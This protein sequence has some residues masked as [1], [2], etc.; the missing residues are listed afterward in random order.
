MLAGFARRHEIRVSAD[1][2]ERRWPMYNDELIRRTPYR[3]IASLPLQLTP[4]LA[5]AVDLYFYDPSGAFTVDLAAAVPIAELMAAALMVASTPTKPSTRV[6]GV[7]LPAWMYSPQ[8]TSR[9]RTW[10]AAGVIMADLGL[11]GPDAMSRLR[12]YAYGQQ[13][14]L[15]EVSNAIIDGTLKL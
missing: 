10:I 7:L 12:A 14:D 6:A 5:G 15:A 8:A 3:S 4:T 13:Q 1:D 2:I 9:L 11:P